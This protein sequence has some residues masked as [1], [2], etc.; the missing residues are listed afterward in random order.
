[1]SVYVSKIIRRFVIDRAA[2]RCEYCRI[3]QSISTA[4]FHIEHIIGLQH[5]GTNSTDNLAWCCAFCNWKKGPNI[6]T[7]LNPTGAV[8]P[9]FNPRTQRW[10]DHFKA[11][12]GY[13]KSLTETGQGTAK[14]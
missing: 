2:N 11:E 5:G 8:L 10:F 6:A 7:M 14:L 4:G 1:M 12:N 9:L 13:I 3:P